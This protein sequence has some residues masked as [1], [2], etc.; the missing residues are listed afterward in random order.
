MIPIPYQEAVQVLR[1]AGFVKTEI[2]RLYRLRQAY[3]TNELDQPQPPLNLNQ[4]LFVRWLIAT[5]R[6]T[7]QFPETE[8]AASPSSKDPRSLFKTLLARFSFPSLRR[9]K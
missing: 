6:L 7:D 1:R 2:D 5:G 3:Q 4:L 8:K 9:K